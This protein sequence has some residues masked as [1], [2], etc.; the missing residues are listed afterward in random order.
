MTC[1]IKVIAPADGTVTQARAL[2]DCAAS[3]SLMTERLAQ[4]LRFVRRRSNFTISGI[5]E[6]DVRP[7]GRVEFKV[8]GIGDSSKYL[9][10]PR[11]TADLPMLPNFSSY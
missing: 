9:P 2:L 6:I 7:K 10:L 5:A 8:D 1:R 3:T 4:Q 11:V